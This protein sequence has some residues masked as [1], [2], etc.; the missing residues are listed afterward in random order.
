MGE[1][2]T[3]AWNAPTTLEAL[4]ARWQGVATRRA[5]WLA[6]LVEADLDATVEL[7]RG[8]LGPRPV[9]LWQRMLH[10]ADHTAVHSGELC[11]AL[12]ALGAPPAEADPFLFALTDA[13][14]P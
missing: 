9:P 13:G 8:E 1:P 7:R 6:T 14:R 10:L 11:A 4:G 3:F 5:A 12:T 2:T